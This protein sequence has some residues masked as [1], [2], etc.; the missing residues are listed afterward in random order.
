MGYHAPAPCFPALRARTARRR[1]WPLIH[2]C[3]V[4][5]V[6]R[7]HDVQP[8]RQL[9]DLLL[10]APQLLLR[11]REKHWPARCRYSSPFVTPCL[12]HAPQLILQQCADDTRAQ[13]HVGRLVG[14]ASRTRRRTRA[15]A[16]TLV[17]SIHACERVCMRACCVSSTDRAHLRVHLLCLDETPVNCPRAMPCWSKKADTAERCIMP[18][19]PRERPL[20]W[21][22]ECDGRP[23]TGCCRVVTAVAVCAG[24]DVVRQVPAWRKTRD[25]RADTT[26]S[27][28]AAGREYWWTLQP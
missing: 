22:L 13:S 21:L 27:P 6:R 8:C 3:A 16:S 9:G 4:G 15:R 12:L 14:A 17:L 25:C 2:S 11:M 24:G 20:R 7:E 5:A 18:S 10:H 28:R 1:C 23:D 19:A 26:Y